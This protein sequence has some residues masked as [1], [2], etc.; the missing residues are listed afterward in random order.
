MEQRMRLAIPCE[1][2]QICAHFGHAPE[3]TFFDVNP[4]TGQIE[5][6]HVLAPPA[7]Q[8]GVLPQ[9]VAEQGATVVLATGMGGRAVDRF[10]Q[11]GVEV[12]IGV[13]TADPRA[14]VEAY[15]KGELQTGANVC[16]HGG[17]GRGGQY[18]RH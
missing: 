4:D 6:E 14:A 3:F 5:N 12:V 9:W 18:G 17:R 7:H 11:H 15:V 2:N 1:G 8:P 10:A 13:T 16:D